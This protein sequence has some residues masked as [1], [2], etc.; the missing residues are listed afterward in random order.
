MYLSNYFDFFFRFL[1]IKEFFSKFKYNYI[2]KLEDCFFELCIILQLDMRIVQ[3]V[4]L[5]VRKDECFFFMLKIN[6]CVR[7]ICYVSK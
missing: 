6:M 4:D 2:L 3:I 1:V 7:E 5:E